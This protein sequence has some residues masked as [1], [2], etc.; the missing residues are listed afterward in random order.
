MQL[1]IQDCGCVLY[2]LQALT[3]DGIDMNARS[4][5]QPWLMAGLT[6]ACAKGAAKGADAMDACF[7][8]RCAA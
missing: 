2:H 5:E 1:A 7:Q 8:M 4:V 3:L 6:Q